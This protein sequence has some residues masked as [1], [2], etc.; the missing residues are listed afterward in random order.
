L[1]NKKRGEPEHFWHVAEIGNHFDCINQSQGATQSCVIPS[2]FF[3][4][5]LSLSSGTGGEKDKE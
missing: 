3:P 2:F 1:Q 5:Y 4:L